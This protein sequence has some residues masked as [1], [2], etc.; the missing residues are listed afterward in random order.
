MPNPTTPEPPVT[1]RSILHRGARIAFDA[2]RGEIEPVATEILDRI[3]RVIGP[4]PDAAYWRERCDVADRRLRETE[5]V[6]RGCKCW[7]RG[8]P[9]H[10]TAKLKAEIARLEADNRKG[11]A[12]ARKL[13]VTNKRL[14]GEVREHETGAVSARVALGSLRSAIN[15]LMDE[16]RIPRGSSPVALDRVGLLVE[17]RRAV[18]E[19]VLAMEHPTVDSWLRIL[20]VAGLPIRLVRVGDE[21]EATIP[22]VTSARASAGLAAIRQA[23][24]VALASPST[25]P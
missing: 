23:V 5:A 8:E 17:Q 12:Y 20:S 11:D 1:L 18:I 21:V 9:T 24:A 4:A 22:G 2:A 16:A 3:D 6:L 10:D 7:Q 19:A 14:E 25:K 15:D 13:E